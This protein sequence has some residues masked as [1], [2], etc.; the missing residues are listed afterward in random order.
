MR[1]RN[2]IDEK[3]LKIFKEERYALLFHLVKEDKDAVN[4]INKFFTKVCSPNL[5][6]PNFF[7]N[8]IMAQH[9]F[10]TGRGIS[11]TKERVWTFDSYYFTRDFR[12]Y[13]KEGEYRK[14]KR[15]TGLNTLKIN[16]SKFGNDV[17]LNALLEEGSIPL[18]DA[19]VQESY[20]EK[21]N[22]YDY[23]LVKKE[24]NVYLGKDHSSYNDKLN[25]IDYTKQTPV[26]I[27]SIQEVQTMFSS[28]LKT[29]EDYLLEDREKQKTRKEV[30]F[31]IEK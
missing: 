20:S 14:E 19:S 26:L 11:K 29:K 4:I 8:K 23:Y 1:N 9:P 31:E 6:N 5:A 30:E 7:Y 18:F 27:G 15:T 3:V 21:A 2:K 22:N 16:F 25:I 24:E 12:Y 13:Y 10:W 28:L 17:N